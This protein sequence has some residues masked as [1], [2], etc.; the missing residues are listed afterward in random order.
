MNTAAWLPA[1]DGYPQTEQ[2]RYEYR[3]WR[4]RSDECVGWLGTG[5]APLGEPKVWADFGAHYKKELLQTGTVLA[6]HHGAAPLGGP[7]FYNPKLNPRSGMLAVISVGKSNTYGHPRAAVLKQALA[8]SA[9]I[10]L[11]T[12]DTAMGLHEVFVLKMR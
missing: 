12:E 1:A 8:A 7:R 3:H 9:N 10:Q 2:C 11:V 5:D 6:P 4:P